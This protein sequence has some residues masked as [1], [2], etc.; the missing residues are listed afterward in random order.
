M[1]HLGL[2]ALCFVIGLRF[3]FA[4]PGEA[5]AGAESAQADRAV[6]EMI[7]RSLPYIEREGVRWIEERKC[8]SCHQVPFMVWS[9]NAAADRGFKLD[10]AQ[11]GQWNQWARDWKSIRGQNQAKEGEEEKTLLGSA[12]ELAQLLIGA[13]AIRPETAGEEET[14]RTSYRK[15]LL[16]QQLEDGSWKPG[17]QLPSQKRRLRE[18]QEV[19]TMWALYAVTSSAA[20]SDV[21][22]AV[23]DKAAK[24]LGDATRGESTEWWSVGLLWQQSRGNTKEAKRFQEELLARQRP[25]GG[26]GW[27]LADESDALGTGQALYAL[28]RAGLPNEPHAIRA[29]QEFLRKTQQ[30]DGA[31][32]VRGTKA[33]KKDQAQATATYWGTCWAV[34]GLT[35]SSRIP[36]PID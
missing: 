15:Y 21:E 5:G 29:A 22:Q 1:R 3:A 16:R 25:D 4:E 12:D 28:T 11:L 23:I 32:S 17:G 9:L 14:W 34:I 36:S 19:T 35:E 33:N 13:P 18:T 8:D 30:P 26:W 7:E 2:T 27:L 24:W 31:W 6:H 20:P 10:T